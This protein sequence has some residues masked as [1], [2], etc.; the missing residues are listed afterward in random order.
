MTEKAIFLSIFF[1]AVCGHMFSGLADK[2]VSVSFLYLMFNPSIAS[3]IFT[4]LTLPDIWK[5]AGCD[6]VLLG[7]YRE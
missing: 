4:G 3:V 1:G 6:F 7:E 5:D 2:H